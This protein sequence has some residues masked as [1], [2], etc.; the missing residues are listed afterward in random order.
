M[1]V[2]G[3]VIKKERGCSYMENREKVLN[4][5]DVKTFNRST[6]LKKILKTE[7]VSRIE[8]SKL[9]GLSPPTVSTVFDELKKND[10]IGEYGIQKSY[11]GRKSILYKISPDVGYVIAAE[12][13]STNIVAGIYNFIGDKVTTYTR[14]YKKDEN[15]L[16]IL[17][18]F[19]NE[20]VSKVG[21]TGKI[22]GIGICLSGYISKKYGFV[23]SKNLGISRMNINEIYENKYG[24][25]LVVEDKIRSAAYYGIWKNSDMQNTGAILYVDLNTGIGSSIVIN[26]K[27]YYGQNDFSGEIGHVIVKDKEGKSC[28][29]GSRGCVETIAS[30][31]AIIEQVVSRLARGEKSIVADDVGGDF[32]NID[33]ETIIKAAGKG[34]KLAF[35]VMTEAVHCILIALISVMRLFDPERI[36]IIDSIGLRNILSLLL[37]QESENALWMEVEDKVSFIEDGEIFLKGA[38]AMVLNDVYESIENYYE[39][40]SL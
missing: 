11:G 14:K 7:P 33:I 8:I 35:D 26:N 17:N 27:I 9:L 18:D 32:E 38:A 22:L 23:E 31:K 25:P 29:C 12:I 1:A 21:A 34:D 20:I 16:K 2:D 6:I 30:E 24:Y 13:R 28:N 19:M 5:A 39:F 40:D 15:L 3:L 36:F 4:N 10:I 37:K